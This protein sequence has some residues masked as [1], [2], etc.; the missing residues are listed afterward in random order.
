MSMRTPSYRLH[1][2][3]G[4]AVCTLS[5][6]DCYLGKFGSTESKDAYLRLIAEWNLAGR[7]LDPRHD[8]SVTELVRD[9]LEFADGYYRKGGRPTSEVGYLEESFRPLKKLYGSTPAED[10]SPLG[11]KATRQAII[12]TGV[13]R[14][15]VNG[16][17]RRIIRLFKWAVENEKVPPSVHHGLT[18]VAGL[19]KGRSAARESEPVKPVPVAFVDA[20]MPHVSPQVR[21]MIELMSL[22]GMRPGEVCQM[23]TADL[24]TSGRIWIYTPGRHKTEHHGKDR[25]IYVGPAAQE[26]LRPWLRTDLE[27]FLF[28]PREAELARRAAQRQTRKTRVQPSQVDRR[29]HSPIKRPGEFYSTTSY[30]LGVRVA[31]KKAA[32]PV[33]HP[34]QLRHNAATRLRREHGIDM[35]RII[36]GHSDMKTTEIYAEADRDKAMAVVGKIG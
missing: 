18:A 21:A 33:W 3:T 35:A 25:Q 24:D 9:Y 4:Q 31:C 5:G 19:R 22:T 28:S 2:A 30:R 11:L 15:V 10:F 7:R 1:K 23:R 20:V 13:C 29:K 16:R 32:V 14:N 17:T 8:L 6:K 12:E 34:N 26:I 36:L 27:G